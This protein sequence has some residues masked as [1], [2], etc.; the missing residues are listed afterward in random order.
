MNIDR[1]KGCFFGSIVG[2]ALGMPYEFKN[3]EHI[4]YVPEMQAGGPFNLPLGCWTDDSIMMLCTA[5]S[6]IEKGKFDIRDQLLKYLRWYEDGYMS[7]YKGCFDVGNQTRKA[8]ENFSK[9]FNAFSTPYD[10]KSSGNG[11]LMRI[12]VFPLAYSEFS[13]VAQF[14][15]Y[16]TMAT[17]N[18][19][20][21]LKYSVDYCKLI[22]A[23]LNGVRKSQIK[24]MCPPV[25]SDIDVDGFVKGS[26]ELA[27]KAFY[28][29]GSFEACMEYVIK[30]GGD[31]DTNACIAGMLAGAYYGYSNIPEAWVKNLIK[32]NDLYSIFNNLVEF[33]NNN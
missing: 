6:L 3:A 30:A 12:N 17:H 28:E 27:V 33:R 8:L 20:L 19:P 23:A 24:I 13:Q 22:H 16:N 31:T 10:L 11:A 5:N 26:F 25:V 32:L 21:C 4:E 9:D 18:N 1:L 2:D 14:A 29:T 7:P 15:Y